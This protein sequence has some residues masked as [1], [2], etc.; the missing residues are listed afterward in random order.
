MA[1][2]LNIYINKPALTCQNTFFIF[3]QIGKTDKHIKSCDLAVFLQSEAHEVV[4]VVLWL[5]KATYLRLVSNS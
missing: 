4:N 1:L 2:Q 3:W 5:C